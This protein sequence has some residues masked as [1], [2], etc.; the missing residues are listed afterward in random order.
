M[1]LVFQ[2]FRFINTNSNS[3]HYLVFTYIPELAY[4]GSD[5]TFEVKH[6]ILTRQLPRLKSYPI[7]NAYLLLPPSRN[8]GASMPQ[9]AI[10]WGPNTPLVV[11]NDRNLHRRSPN[12]P[13]RLK[14]L[15][16]PQNRAKFTTPWPASPRKRQLL[17][18]RTRSSRSPSRRSC[19]W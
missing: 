7:R 9:I 17:R 19:S 15:N 5:R 11:E 3:R 2:D 12:G 16:F 13:P 6:N 8:P 10:G 1:V 18:T 14:L 4:G